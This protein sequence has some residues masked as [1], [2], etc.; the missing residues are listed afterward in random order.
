MK[1]SK[2]LE[3]VKQFMAVGNQPTHETFRFVSTKIANFRAELIREEIHGT[4]ELVDSVKNDDLVGIVDGMADILY[5]VY[6]AM[7]TH[8]VVLNSYNDVEIFGSDRIGTGKVQYKHVADEN[9]YKIDTAYAKYVNST[10]TGNGSG[11]EES[12]RNIIVWVSHM[13]KIWNL[14]LSGAFV[15]VHNSN[16]SKFASSYSHGHASIEERLREGHAMVAAGKVLKGEEQIANYT[17]AVVDQIVVGDDKYY[18]IKR[19]SD[20]KILKSTAFFEP[21]LSKFA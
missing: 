13:A 14:D 12:L 21:D 17:G 8:G 11:I 5:V 15:E 6:G 9:I 4:N 16:M 10:S 18:A 7:A 3:L 20:G 19:K 2:Q 1:A